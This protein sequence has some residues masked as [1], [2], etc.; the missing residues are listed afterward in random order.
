MQSQ[1]DAK[2]VA[3]G[4]SLTIIV[5]HVRITMPLYDYE[6]IICGQ[7]QELEH[8]MSAAANP[9]LHCSTPMIR[10]FSATP[11]IFKGTGWGKDKK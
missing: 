1:A 4:Y 7:T 3:L 11:A 8:S 6:C 10:V 9:V 5:K 2:A